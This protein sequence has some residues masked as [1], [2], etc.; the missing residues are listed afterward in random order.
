MDADRPHAGHTRR[1]APPQL[2][3]RVTALALSGNPFDAERATRLMR[4][5]RM[6][7]FVRFANLVF[8]R[9]QQHSSPPIEHHAAV[10]S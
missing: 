10:D 6:I 4:M 7:F 9:Q 5:L 2:H 3:A 1:R 8:Q